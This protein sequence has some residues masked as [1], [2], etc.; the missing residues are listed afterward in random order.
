MKSPGINAQDLK[1]N[2]DRT[3]DLAYQLAAHVIETALSGAAIP[4]A[5][6]AMSWC[7]RIITAMH[8]KVVEHRRTDELTL[9]IP[10]GP[11]FNSG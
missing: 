6:Q 10:D 3:L 1:A 5:D 11:E 4:S 9:S 8:P 7:T 2:S